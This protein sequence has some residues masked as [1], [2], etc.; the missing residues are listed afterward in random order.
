MLNSTDSSGTR[1]GH[2]SQSMPATEEISTKQ[3]SRLAGLRGRVTAA[4]LRELH[5]PRRQT[6]VPEPEKVDPRDSGEH[7][8]EELSEGL[9]EALHEATEEAPER[10]SSLRG[11]V[12]IADLRGLHPGERLRDSTTKPAGQ[13]AGEMNVHHEAASTTEVEPIGEIAAAVAGKREKAEIS[14]AQN[15]HGASKPEVAHS[16]IQKKVSRERG[17]GVEEIRTLPSK[18]GQYRHKN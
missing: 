9:I 7:E 13:N 11:L 16:G 15:G 4:S 1:R 18:R 6:P 17:D 14:A 2:D 8:F 5:R 12:T 3:P 10:L